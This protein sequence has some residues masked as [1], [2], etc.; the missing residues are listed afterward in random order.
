[1]SL[2][3][4][5]IDYLA[6]DYASFRRL[7]FDRLALIM[8]GWQERHAADLGV[9]LVEVLAYHAD[10]LSYYQDAAATEAYLDTAR[11]RISV[12]RHARLVDY[13]LHEGCN[14][15]A[16][17]CLETD[18]EIT[19]P[20]GGYYF[21]TAARGD[22]ADG[23]WALSQDDV[24]KLPAGSFDVFEPLLPG[25]VQILPA[26]NEIP[27]WT[28]GG[29]ACCLPAG[30]TRAT[31]K[32][33]WADDQTATGGGDY[34]GTDQY[35]ARHAVKP[36]KAHKPATQ[37]RLRLLRLRPGDI[38]IFEEVRGPHTNIPADA[39]AAHRQAV[40]LTR[41]TPGMDDLCGQ[42]VVEV[43]W[44][45]EDALTFQLC[46]T[47]RAQDCGWVQPVSVARGNVVLVD[48]GT[49]NTR[50]G[51]PPEPLPIPGTVLPA[52]PVCDDLAAPLAPEPG[53]PL[54]LAL[55]NGPLTWRAGFPAPDV[56]SAAQASLLDNIP[57]RVKARVRDLRRQ[58]RRGEALNQA[59]TDELLALYGWAVLQ[60]AGFPM[61]RG[62]NAPGPDP[63]DQMH[64]LT[65]LLAHTPP[66]LARKLA[67]I[68]TLAARA[69]AGYQLGEAERAEIETL[70]GHD[71]ADGLDETNPVWFG[72]AVTP[73]NRTCGRRSLRSGC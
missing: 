19:L 25:E 31:L 14:A 51:A 3:E 55:A 60:A 68:A 54:S 42:P 65:R 72:P 2:P 32:D 40:R 71:Y 47:A 57:D 56:V 61:P 12:R 16:W 28:W 7:I 48:H 10:Q 18:A 38:M 63:A 22:P 50:C 17:V 4:P 15:R 23:L 30:S 5:N 41:V 20:D 59:E 11:L 37:D 49:L 6:K 26:H 13:T 1:M 33:E 70:L 35:A 44:A 45:P 8:P 43:E 53:P 21:I 39:D 34:G 66:A 62:R 24:R 64:A 67:Y 46:I 27:L 52:L 73:S 69:R 58:A 36:P 9:A 29:E